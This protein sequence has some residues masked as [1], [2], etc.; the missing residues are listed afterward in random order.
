[1]I[2]LSLQK[3]T[4]FYGAT[5]VLKDIS[6]ELNTSDRAGIIGRN[7]TGK[8]T[9]MKLIAGIENY[10]D[11]SMAFRKDA[12]VGYLDQIPVYPDE[13]KVIDVLE[14][15]FKEIATLRE[16]M[17]VLEKEMSNISDGKLDK[18]MSKYSELQ[19]EFERMGGYETEEKYSKVCTGLKIDNIFK[20]RRFNQLSGG[21]KTTVIL[22]K[23]LLQ[24]PQILLLDEPTNHLDVQS[25][26]WLESFLRE[27][28]GC[29]LLISH[30]RYFLDRVVNK[31]IEIEGGKS[32]VFK[33]NYS[34][35]TKEKELKLI[36]QEQDYKRQ[37]KK[38]KEMEDAAKRFRD[39]GERA[40]N[41][42]M[43]KKAFNMEKR[44]EKMDKI[45]KPKQNKKIGL[46][47]QRDRKNSKD[48]VIVDSLSFSY[49]SKPIFREADLLLRSNEKVAIIGKNGCGKST[50][51]KLLLGGIDPLKGTAK[52][53]S[54]VKYGYLEQ[55]ITFPQPD[56]TVLDYIRE[57]L[58]YTEFEA[59]SLLSKYLFR[60]DDVYKKISVL[61]GGEK[62]RLRLCVMLV[63]KVNTLIF[64]EPTNHLDIESRENLE[65]TLSSF[66]GTIVFISHDRY[67]INKIANNIVEIKDCKFYKYDG[68]YDNYLEESK[69]FIDKIDN[70]KKIKKVKV[71]VNED[72]KRKIKERKIEKLEQ[73]IKDYESLIKKKNEEM[74][75]NQTDHIVLGQLFEEI[76]SLKEKL[77][78]LMEK[79]FELQD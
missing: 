60:K 4:K 57:E 54:G 42:A 62:V 68:N 55:E 49:D 73:E 76:Q 7:G 63:N 72:S 69:K 20:Q 56:K 17:R 28:K 75:L 10:N 37:Q 32:I 22:G 51:F 39:W 59:R 66:E 1:M 40:D 12:S 38:L 64:D 71:R 6:F 9:L 14:I 30:D 74:E 45:D 21:E 5:Q 15:A 26:E 53:G 67:F 24:N 48:V 31:I 70:K 3:I 8:T 58:K 61:S 50:I 47:I 35:Y 46:Q 27:Y 41:K 78:E 44:I 79:W 2:E 29:V 43:F 34:T 16:R 65:E 36:R 33:G 13:Y 19:L 18:T 23:L 25:I 77:E 11:G 52:L